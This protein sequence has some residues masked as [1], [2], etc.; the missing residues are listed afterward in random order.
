MVECGPAKQS[1]GYCIVQM[2]KGKV[3]NLNIITQ[4]FLSEETWGRMVLTFM[5]DA[6]EERKIWEDA[7]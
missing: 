4:Q 1:Q 2:G 3:Q 7:E 5:I 6:W